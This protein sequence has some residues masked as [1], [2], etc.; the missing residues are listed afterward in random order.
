MVDL[1]RSYFKNNLAALNWYYG[2][3]SKSDY[4]IKVFKRSVT[5]NLT[6][7][8]KDKPYVRDEEQ[9]CFNCPDGSLYNLGNETCI[10]CGINQ[11]YN[12]KTDKCEQC[13]GKKEIID[14]TLT[15]KPCNLAGLEVYNLTSG[16]C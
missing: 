6:S 10:I 16:K 11:V 15:C 13:F 4:K 14:Q 8:P 3:I 1:N 9:V 5:Y 7:C 12:I 2:A